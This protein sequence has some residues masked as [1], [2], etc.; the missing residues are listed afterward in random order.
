MQKNKVQTYFPCFP[1]QLSAAHTLSWR[2]RH[3][4]RQASL[5][6]KVLKLVWNTSLAEPWMG[7][8]RPVLTQKN[9][10]TP[11][12]ESTCWASTHH[13]TIY[14]V[15]LNAAN[16][17][18]AQIH[19]GNSRKDNGAAN[20]LWVRRLHVTSNGFVSHF[21]RG[22]RPSDLFSLWFLDLHLSVFPD[23]H[24]FLFSRCKRIGLFPY[25]EDQQFAC[26]TSLSGR[27]VTVSFPG[28]H[29]L[30]LCEVEIYGTMKGPPCLFILYYILW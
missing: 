29:F 22:F 20:A 8:T 16:I 27:Y 10:W 4:S 24:L 25:D 2:G 7:T 26:D 21:Q 18:G 15:K 28:K 3:P 6:M 14:Q 19:I 12:G 13:I 5:Q 17:T 9:R 1:P 23:V 30:A 11:G